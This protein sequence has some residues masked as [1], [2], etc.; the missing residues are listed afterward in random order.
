MYFEI[1]LLN[2]HERVSVG[3]FTYTDKVL[4]VKK[5]YYANINRRTPINDIQFVYMGKTMEDHKKLEYYED[6]VD[7]N[8]GMI[9]QLTFRV[10]GGGGIGGGNNEVNNEAKDDAK[11]EIKDEVFKPVKYNQYIMIFYL[12]VIIY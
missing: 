1:Y 7:P 10:Q 8:F 4:K 9:I 12:Y 3:K 11:D 6:K 5:Y 2:G